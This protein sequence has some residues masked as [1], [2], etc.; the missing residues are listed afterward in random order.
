MKEVVKSGSSNTSSR[1]ATGFQFVPRP[2]KVAPHTLIKDTQSSWYTWLR[3]LEAGLKC[4]LITGTLQQVWCNDMG[5]TLVVGLEADK[6]SKTL[7]CKDVDLLMDDSDAI[8]FIPWSKLDDVYYIKIKNKQ[9]SEE[10]KEVFFADLRRGE[11]W[12]LGEIVQM[13]VD[14]SSFCNFPEE[15]DLGVS[16]KISTPAKVIPTLP[17]ALE[18][19][20]FQGMFD[21]AF[22]P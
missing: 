4:V 7:Q 20:D 11:G 12:A 6:L 15:G 22:F 8:K 21:D 17:A 19:T 3:V 2:K 14:I 1:R 13:H 18:T 9:P 10:A 16:V 5:W